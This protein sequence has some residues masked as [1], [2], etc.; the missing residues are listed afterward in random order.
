MIVSRT[1]RLSWHYYQHELLTFP[2]GQAPEFLHGWLTL[3]WQNDAMR[4]FVADHCANGSQ[5]VHG[6]QSRGTRETIV[7]AL[8]GLVAPPSMR[9]RLAETPDLPAISRLVQ[10]LADFEKEPDAVNVT[11]AQYAVDGFHTHRP[12]FYCFLMETERDENWYASGMAFC[13]VGQNYDTGRFLYLVD[14]FIEEPYRGNGAGKFVMRS[15]A[16]I[17]LDLGCSKMVWQA[18]NWNTPALAFYNKIGANVVEGLLTARFK[19]D[20]L[21]ALSTMWQQSYC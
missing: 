19:G 1:R 13:Y 4:T 12:L 20:S 18:L 6:L 16:T 21:R 11:S 14:L 5:E 3:H 7:L 10:G 15:L 9:L 2:G 8:Q 17:A